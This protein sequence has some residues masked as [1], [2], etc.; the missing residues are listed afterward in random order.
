MMWGLEWRRNRRNKSFYP[1]TDNAYDQDYN[2]ENF[3]DAFLSEI[4]IVPTGIAENQ[5]GRLSHVS[6]NQP[7]PF[8]TETTITY[9]LDTPGDV[10]LEVYDCTGKKVLERSFSNM[11]TG[12][13]RIELNMDG[14]T[15]GLYFYSLSTGHWTESL[16]MIIE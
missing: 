8:R 14:F 11:K 10:I 5:T 3:G 9:R 1:V 16:K 13:H 15:P 7:N 12:K 4:G 2:S 6:Q